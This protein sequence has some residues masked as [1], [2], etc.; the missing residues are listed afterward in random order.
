MKTRD[1]SMKQ[2]VDAVAKQAESEDVMDEQAQP[3]SGTAPKGRPT[4]SRKQAQAAKAQP[5]IPNKKDKDAIRAQKLLER[6]AREKARVGAMMGDEKYLPARDRGPQRK[7]VRDVVDARFNFG[8]WMIPLMV[9]VLLLTLVPN[10]Q[11][12]LIFLA[13]I[14][15]Y[16]A[17]SIVDAVIVGRKAYRRAVEKWG[18][19]KVESGLKMYAAMRSLQMRMLRM[20]KPQVK[21]GATVE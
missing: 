6:E 9:V 12:Q 20:P 10:E 14:W 19:D 15:V 11:L 16:V 8:E 1:R 21:R 17:I 4:P 7:F 3:K 18:A 13:S 5:L 2:E